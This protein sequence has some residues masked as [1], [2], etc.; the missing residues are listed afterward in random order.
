MTAA[1]ILFFYSLFFLSISLQANNEQNLPELGDSTS[2]IISLQKEREIGQ[3]FLRSLR[4]QVETVADPLLK[5]Y[6]EHLI[7]RLA[8]NS[9]LQD[10]HLDLVII[11]SK[12]LNAFAAP[13]GIIGINLGL[14][15]NADTEHEFS[16]ILAHELAH[17]SQRHFARQFETAK[18]TGAKTLVGLLAGLIL[19]ATTG[20]DAGMAALAMSQSVAQN[21]TLKYSRSRETEADRIGI[22]TLVRSSMD[23]LAMAYMFEQLNQLKRYQGN[24]IPEFLSTHPITQKRISD[25]YNQ[26]QKYP[27]KTYPAKLDYQL[28]RSRVQVLG[29]ESLK[30]N[31]ARMRPGLRYTDPAKKTASQYGLLLALTQAGELKEASR[32][33]KELRQSH[34]DKIAF[35]LAE[36]E[37]QLA[38]G[39]TKKAIQ[40]LDNALKTNPNNHP[41]TMMVA[42][43]WL[44]ADQ[45]A[46]AEQYL[47]NLTR[48]RANDS[49]LWYELAE[50]QGLADNIPGLHQARAEYFVLTGNLDQAI[51]QLEYALPLAN[52]NFHL[53]AKI[54][55]RMEDIHT[56][57][58]KRL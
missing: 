18:T 26:A 16:A 53:S 42:Q 54:S 4:S 45:P 39:Q 14:F 15:L 31:E 22:D 3:E 46:K 2:G 43:A 41:L 56:M 1:R 52:D 48:F 7:Y 55:Q 20:A 21:E 36:A 28:M 13:G 5:D 58:E 19:I 50:T 49:D 8:E 30:A 47:T 12:E 32:L 40:I 17:L 38:T 34:P 57:R 23:P 44:K 24:R 33:V 27:V 37:I 35:I 11:D 6:L 25:S 51:K 29:E 10:K 9:Q